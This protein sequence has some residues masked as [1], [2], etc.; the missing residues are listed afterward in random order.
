MS[1]ILAGH[2]PETK[3]A[4]DWHHLDLFNNPP[5]SD[6]DMVWEIA[7]GRFIIEGKPSNANYA[8]MYCAYRD[9]KEAWDALKLLDEQDLA[10]N[11]PQIW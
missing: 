7:H 1:T 11:G 3:E 4:F 5:Y 8:E 9:T 6:G 2:E 10:I